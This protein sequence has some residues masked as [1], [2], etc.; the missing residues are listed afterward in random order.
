[1]RKVLL[2]G[3]VKLVYVAPVFMNLLNRIIPLEV[4]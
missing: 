2:G 3:P 4:S 1:M